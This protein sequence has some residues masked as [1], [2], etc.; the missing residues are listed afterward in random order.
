MD[1]R[2][3]NDAR[4][5]LTTAQ[6]VEEGLK[7]CTRDGVHPALLFMEQAGVPR[8]VALRVLCS[9]RYFRQKDRSVMAMPKRR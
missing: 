3:K 6:S 2:S 9:P 7:R 8:S 4:T 5:D 1:D